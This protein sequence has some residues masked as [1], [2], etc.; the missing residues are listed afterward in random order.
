MFF[1]EN[2]TEIY[3]EIEIQMRFPSLIFHRI[4]LYAFINAH[5]LENLL[6]FM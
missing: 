6:S 4:I 1:V 5:A 3:P 2:F